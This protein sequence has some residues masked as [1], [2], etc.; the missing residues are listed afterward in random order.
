ML[1]LSFNF[2]IKPFTGVILVHALNIPTIKTKTRQ[3]LSSLW[4]LSALWS[5]LHFSNPSGIYFSLCACTS[6]INKIYKYYKKIQ[7]TWCNKIDHHYHLQ[8]F[9]I[10]SQKCNL[11]GKVSE[12]NSPWIHV[13]L[14]FKTI[15]YSFLYI[16]FLS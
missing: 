11:R 7:R 10:L 2:N 8:L 14:Y 13:S 4:K 6:L 16:F 15:I 12:L 5:L 9:S 3:L 1:N